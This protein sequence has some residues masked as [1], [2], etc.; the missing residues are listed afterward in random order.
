MMGNPQG[1]SRLYL[2]P[3]NGRTW[4]NLGTARVF[5]TTVSVAARQILI[6]GTRSL[7]CA[8]VDRLPIGP[9]VANLPH[10]ERT[11]PSP[12][13]RPMSPDRPIRGAGAT[14]EETPEFRRIGDPRADSPRHRQSDASW[15]S[16]LASRA[17][18]AG[19]RRA[20]PRSSG[21]PQVPRPEHR[22][23]NSRF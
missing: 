9:Q 1:V 4:G 19:T 23:S 2:S 22:H 7:G 21:H 15:L 18:I 20:A 3:T 8:R 6:A 12:T 14:G 17:P 16:P 5:P 13:S 11:K 10:K